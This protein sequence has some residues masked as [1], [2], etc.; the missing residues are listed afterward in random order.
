MKNKIIVGISL[1]AGG[2]DFLTGLLLV[3]LPQ[4]TLGLMGVPVVSELVWVRFVGTFVGGVG[5]SY[6]YGLLL[7]LWSNSSLRLQI[8]WEVTALLRLLVALFVSVEIGRGD[9]AHAWFMV[10]LCDGIWAA[11]QLGLIQKGIFHHDSR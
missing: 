7:W 5:L 2:G 9:L 3:L 11:V 4:T 6:L 1:I 10:P 8:I